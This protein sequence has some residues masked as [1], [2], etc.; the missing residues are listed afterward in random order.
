MSAQLPAAPRFQFERHGPLL[1]AA[2]LFLLVYWVDLSNFNLG[3]DEE[4][5]TFAGERWRPWLQQG[6]WGMSLVTW[7]LPP[8]EAVPLIST[9]L[10]GAG[11]LLA[12]AR[13]LRD[14]ELRGGAA[15][16]FALVHVGLPVW[17]HIA[18]FSTLAAG[19]G[20]G[21]AAAAWGAG[22][23]AEE[24]GS[25]WLVGV[26]LLAFASAVYQTLAVYAALYLWLLL[27]ART[28]P[29]S[30]ALPWRLALRLGGAWLAALLL[31][32]ACQWLLLALT[33]EQ[34]AYIGGFVQSEHL[35]ADPGG[36]WHESW[37]FV[38]RLVNGK[39]EAYLDMGI[40][41]LVMS[42]LGLLAPALPAGERYPRRLLRTFVVF[43][44]G[45]LLLWGPVFLAYATLPVRAQVAWP[46]LAA[47][48]AARCPFPD[49]RAP[50]LRALALGYFALVAATVGATVFHID[51][52]VREGDRQLTAQLVPRLRAVAA[53]PGG[54]PP[55]QPIPFT[56]SG[57]HQFPY[58]GKIRAVEM[59]GVSFF[60]HDGGSAYRMN[61]YWRVLGIEGFSPRVLSE[62]PAAQ[63][64]AATMP[65]WPAPDSVK[66][67]DGVVVVRFGAPTPGQLRRP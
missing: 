21:I 25:R 30:L 53:A 37:R 45:L 44:V 62:V 58:A 22:L 67:V 59:Y 24:R 12:T 16:S 63:A 14:F 42:W 20:A 1:A 64:A 41:L 40:A 47:W 50:W 29:G 26:A 15:W 36:A 60:E 17:L 61:Y 65:D 32:F 51:N 5:A 19:F 33:G 18:Q 55:G 48:L 28:P 49:A 13:A 23:C 3:I 43:G 35:R 52:V 57:F 27:A 2:L 54:I 7:L 38:R 8:F 66:L 31:Y 4:I 46:L 9:L 10:M 6:R 56:V 39:N 34:L 11:L